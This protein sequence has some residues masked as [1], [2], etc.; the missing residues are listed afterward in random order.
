MDEL[1]GAVEA[2]GT[3]FIC[4]VGKNHKN[5]HRQTAI[6]TDTPEN[7]LNACFDFFKEATSTFG[8]LSAVGLAS[9]GP[10]DLDK[11]SNT[12]GAL[13]NTPKQGWSDTN[14]YASLQN[15]LGVPVAVDTDV[16]CAVLAEVHL[17]NAKG[18]NS[19]VYVTIGTGVG[20][21]VYINGNL[22]HGLIH[23]ELGHIP[24]STAPEDKFAG[25]C[26]FHGNCLEGLASGPALAARWGQP[27]ETLADDHMCWELEAYYL[28]QMCLT[29]TLLVSP[30]RIVLGGG[31]MAK[32]GLISAIHQKFK[33]LLANYLPIEERAGGLENYI[34]PQ[35][36]NG[37][38]GL[39]GA[40]ILAHS[41]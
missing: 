24:V 4:A 35:S 41:L 29:I 3:K 8:P 19:A 30:E 37:I 22:I 27:A 15:H 17:G 28:A 10:L 26:S 18:C 38:S 7:T 23:S 6:P 25:I 12:Y 20:A 36:L 33:E 11:N 16:N 40:F 31:V 9:F 13:I 14:I 5:I 2:G 1:L 34:V 39:A 32:Q 21:G